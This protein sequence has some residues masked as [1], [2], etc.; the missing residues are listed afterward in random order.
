MQHCALR[1]ETTQEQ[2]LHWI[3]CDFFL[4]FLEISLLVL[5]I[6]RNE[7]TAHRKRK[8]LIRQISF[9][10]VKFFFEAFSPLLIL[11]KF[12]P[13]HHS[14]TN[15]YSSLGTVNLPAS[16]NHPWGARISCVFKFAI[17]LKPSF[18]HNKITK[19]ACERSEA[20]IINLLHAQEKWTNWE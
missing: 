12:E 1:R 19:D 15:T 13:E 10:S 18:S 14:V 16:K 6:R 5:T 7:I 3:C 8:R 20:S 4:F 17:P 9:V 11:I 2:S